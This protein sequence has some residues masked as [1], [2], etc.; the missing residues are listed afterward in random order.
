M[1]MPNTSAL[2]DKRRLVDL[3]ITRGNACWKAHKHTKHCHREM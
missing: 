1:T 2:N 3:P